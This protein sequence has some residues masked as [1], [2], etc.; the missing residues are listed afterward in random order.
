MFLHGKKL[1]K[2]NFSF[3]GK[4]KHILIFYLKEIKFIKILII[5]KLV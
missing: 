1:N 5:H 4:N 3:Y 2:N